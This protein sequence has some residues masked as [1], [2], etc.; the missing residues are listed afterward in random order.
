MLLKK[1]ITKVSSTFI[2]FGLLSGCAHEDAWRTQDTV[3]QVVL[4]AVLIADAHSTSNIQYTPNVWEAGPIASKVLGL[5]PS[6]SDTWQYFTTLAISHYFITR[7]MPAKWRPYW[8][9]FNTGAHAWAVW[10]NCEMNLC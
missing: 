1:S 10:G 9:G 3:G 2:V 5:Q 7:A 8:Q 4:T 6:T